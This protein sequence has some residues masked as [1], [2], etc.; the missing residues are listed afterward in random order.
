[1]RQQGRGVTPAFPPQ[2]NNQEEVLE[3]RKGDRSVSRPGRRECWLGKDHP[4]ETVGRWRAEH[5]R[6]SGGPHVCRGVYV[7]EMGSWGGCD[8][9]VKSVLSVAIVASVCS[10]WVLLW[11]F[12]PDSS[13]VVLLRGPL[14]LGSLTPSLSW[15]S[16]LGLPG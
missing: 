13:Q 6:L 2:E 5:R 12:C 4:Q 16:Q 10:F 7:C 15:D 11:S 9:S 14:V 1:M 8:P 3:G